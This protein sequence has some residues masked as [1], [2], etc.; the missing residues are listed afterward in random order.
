MRTGSFIVV[1]AAGGSIYIT[2]D[3]EDFEVL[4]TGRAMRCLWRQLYWSNVVRRPSYPR[5]SMLNYV[6]VSVEIPHAE[7]SGAY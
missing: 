5:A 4:G 7:F 1:G 2:L 3:T 6:A